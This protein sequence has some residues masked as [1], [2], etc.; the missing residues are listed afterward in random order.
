MVVGRS[1]VARMVAVLVLGLGAQACTSG[2]EESPG[3]ELGER[4]SAFR[5]IGKRS[6]SELN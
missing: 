5:D 1:W 4:K 6:A 3:F 2:G